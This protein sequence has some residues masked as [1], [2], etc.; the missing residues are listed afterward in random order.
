MAAIIALC[1][2]QN[3]GKTE[4]LKRL[5]ALIE[6]KYGCSATGVHK[7][8]HGCKR[9][10]SLRKERV[11]TFK[12]GSTKIGITTRGDTV[13]LLEDDFQDMGEDCGVYVCAC[14]PGKSFDSFFSKKPN[15][16][17]TII[18]R[19]FVDDKISRNKS[20]TSQRIEDLRSKQDDSQAAELL[21]I[22]ESLL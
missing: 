2:D 21:K 1:G 5:I 10:S 17:I 13:G 14:H 7:N 16:E 8:H 4:T 6:K 20:F 3:T 22:I 12:I 19:S 11:V 18:G 9:K 15:D